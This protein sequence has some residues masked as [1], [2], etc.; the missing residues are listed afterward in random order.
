MSIHRVLFSFVLRLVLAS[1]R[2]SGQI[3][4]HAKHEAS[5]PCTSQS[6]SSPPISPSISREAEGD[7]IAP[8][9]HFLSS[10]PTCGGQQEHGSCRFS[11]VNSLI[12]PFLGAQDLVP[13]FACNRAEFLQQD[14][15]YLE[16][17]RVALDTEAPERERAAVVDC[18]HLLFSFS[19][20][21]SSTA[22]KDG[23][24]LVLPSSSNFPR[25]RRRNIKSRGAGRGG[26]NIEGRASS[27]AEEK[28]LWRNTSKRG[29][30]PPWSG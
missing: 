29:E 3:V 2:I 20:V 28:I 10:S 23:D 26:G 9:G 7:H 19:G 30:H 21:K 22:T 17:R 1:R 15:L 11:E 8:Q 24:F 5:P 16:K 12:L 14:L 27:P 25:S 4:L 6:T 18:L 13:C